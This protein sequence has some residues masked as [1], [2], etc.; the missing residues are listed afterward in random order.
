MEKREWY[1]SFVLFGA[2]M[3]AFLMGYGDLTGHNPPWSLVLVW[4]GANTVRTNSL[5]CFLKH[6]GVRDDKFLGT[7][8]MRSDLYERCY[9]FS[10]RAHNALTTGSFSIKMRTY[11]FLVNVIKGG[12]TNHTS[13]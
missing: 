6:E 7:H 4:M 12:Y 5:T 9:N 10:D 2:G 3:Q 13:W 11:Y 1:Y 8:P